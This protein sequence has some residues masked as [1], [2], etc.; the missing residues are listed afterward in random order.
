MLNSLV[1]PGHCL[2]KLALEEV[3]LGKEVEKPESHGWVLLIIV[4]CSQN[5]FGFHGVVALSQEDSNKLNLFRDDIELSHVHHDRW[6]TLNDQRS[7]VFLQVFEEIIAL[8]V[9]EPSTQ[10]S[11]DPWEA[12]DILVEVSLDDALIGLA[13]LDRYVRWKFNTFCGEKL[14][15]SVKIGCVELQEL[16]IILDSLG[17]VAQSM[18]DLAE[19]VRSA[20][21][22]DNFGIV[23]SD[24]LKSLRPFALLNIATNTQENNL[25]ELM[26][27]HATLRC[28]LFLKH[29]HA[30]D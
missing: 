20:H 16:L 22:V 1:N 9:P 3:V 30:I 2:V 18:V 13:K 12:Q 11:I 28:L 6:D 5:L 8:K 25:T 15:V 21:G 19:L 26:W 24:E 14:L 17:L 7:H 23:V 27:L 4:A 10:V 29:D